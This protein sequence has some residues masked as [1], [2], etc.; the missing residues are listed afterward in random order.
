[1]RPT[2]GNWS[3]WNGTGSDLSANFKMTCSTRDRCLSHLRRA[4]VI[5]R[6]RHVGTSDNV[7][8]TGKIDRRASPVL[9]NPDPQCRL[10]TSLDSGWIGKKAAISSVRRSGS[11][12]I[13]P[14]GVTR[15]E[16]VDRRM[17]ASQTFSRSAVER[18]RT[19]HILCDIR[20]PLGTKA[21]DLHVSNHD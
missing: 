19:C 12:D 1:M 20:L 6:D 17:R 9:S 18:C 10:T 15:A 3:K 21:S 14:G 5:K 8:P 16:K 7:S 13:H 11:A 4:H 2:R